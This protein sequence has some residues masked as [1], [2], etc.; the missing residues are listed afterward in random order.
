MRVGITSIFRAAEQRFGAAA[1]E[2][3]NQRPAESRP[4]RQGICGRRHHVASFP[5]GKKIWHIAST[6]SSA[7]PK[8]GYICGRSVLS[9]KGPPPSHTPAAGDVKFRA[10]IFIPHLMGRGPSTRNIRRRDDLRRKADLQGLHWKGL[11]NRG[12]EEFPGERRNEL[13][14]RTRPTPRLKVLLPRSGR[15][16]R[17]AP[18]DTSI[19]CRTSWSSS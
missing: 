11:R 10:V 14:Y 6:P 5:P 17:C 19:I 15:G 16:S 4:Q 7:A 13:L 1:L 12:V 3:L 18:R 8:I 9:G 2:H